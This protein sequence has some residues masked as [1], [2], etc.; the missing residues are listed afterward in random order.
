MNTTI[1]AA[2][3]KTVTMGKR[4]VGILSR[5]GSMVVPLLSSALYTGQDT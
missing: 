3:S 1:L 5:I 4:R 2:T